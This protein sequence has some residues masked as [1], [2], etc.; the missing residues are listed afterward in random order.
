M[1]L[2]F[3]VLFMHNMKNNKRSRSP[4]EC[5]GKSMAVN[6]VDPSIKKSNCKKTT[7]MHAHALHSTSLSLQRFSLS[8]TQ[9]FFCYSFALSNE[10]CG[11][12][13][14]KIFLQTMKKPTAAAVVAVMPTVS[15]I[16]K[17]ALTEILKIALTE[18]LRIVR[19]ETKAISTAALSCVVEHEHLPGS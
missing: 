17:I 5:R 14:K 10:F 9:R 12:H 16:L 4:V 7:G 1:P 15:E 8:N 6:A 3:L 11:H 13:A 19:T 18:I 2:V